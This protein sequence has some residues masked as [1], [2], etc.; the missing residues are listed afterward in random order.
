MRQ[1]ASGVKKN[2]NLKKSQY[3]KKKCCNETIV[4]WLHAV[5]C[6]QTVAV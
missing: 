5:A 4:I 3:P 2:E 6:Q 1:T